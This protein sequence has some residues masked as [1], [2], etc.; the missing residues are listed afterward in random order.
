MLN[1][2]LRFF[3]KKMG[4]P[5]RLIVSL[6]QPALFNMAAD[7][8]LLS[9]YR[10]PTL[11]IYSWQPQAISLGR[12]QAIN[13]VVNLSICREQNITVIRRTTGGGAVFHD[14]EIT[15]SLIIAQNL[16]SR[17]TDLSESYR[18]INQP[19]IDT[20][21]QIGVRAK[22]V[23]IN[24]LVVNDKKISGC[25]QTRKQGI[26]LQHGTILFDLDLPLMFSCLKISPA[27][28][29]DKEIKNPSLRVTSLANEGVNCS[30]K[31]FIDLL[32]ANFQRYL[33]IDFNYRPFDKTEQAI[34]NKIGQTKFNSD[35]T[36]ER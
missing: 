27:K 9:E 18:F 29:A 20:L 35:W 36:Y 12:F 34:I 14:Q 2:S 3:F 13:Q 28:I 5:G 7:E 17:L 10:L 24:D 16:D 33:T 23:P 11:R 31:K 15:Y 32:V 21:R 26:I 1:Q 22:F 25:A 30:S 6:T 8:Y 19:I 4:K